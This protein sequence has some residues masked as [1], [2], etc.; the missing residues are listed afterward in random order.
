MNWHHNCG[1]EKKKKKLQNQIWKQRIFCSFFLRWEADGKEGE[2][3][4]TA[5]CIS[6]GGECDSVLYLQCRKV[7]SM[8]HKTFLS[9]IWLVI[10]SQCKQILYVDT[11]THTFTKS[12][13]WA[14]SLSAWAYIKSLSFIVMAPFSTVF[15]LSSL[16]FCT[17][18]TEQQ[19]QPMHLCPCVVC[20]ACLSVLSIHLCLA[21]VAVH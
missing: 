11:H 16:L 9:W 13:T 15:P 12:S 8:G 19:L 7:E 3:N 4:L 20:M 17:Q 2:W 10:L 5:D 1:R 21:C 6:R 18:P 14:N